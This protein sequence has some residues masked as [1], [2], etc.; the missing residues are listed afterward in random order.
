VD[1]L[2]TLCYLMYVVSEPSIFPYCVLFELNWM[3]AL[4]AR[5]FIVIDLT[6][7]YISLF[8]Y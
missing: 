5:L 7:C 4:N 8:C 6:F 2:T 3:Q 1:R